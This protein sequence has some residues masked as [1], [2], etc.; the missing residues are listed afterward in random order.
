MRVTIV[1]CGSIGKRHSENILSLGHQV[2][3]IDL[4]DELTYD[5]D[6][7]F[8][9][10]P[11]QFHVQHAY[12]FLSRGIP[13]FIEKPLTHSLK[14][15]TELSKKLKGNDTI[16]MVGCNLRFHPA[17]RDAKDIAS[18]HRV[19]FARAEYGYYLPF[20]RKGDYRKSYSAGSDGGIIIDDI[21][22]IDYLYWLFGDIVD[23]KM[24]FGK[25]SDL[26]IQQED[27]SEVAIL[28]QNGVSA[29]VHQDYLCKNYHRT[30][31]L[32][33]GHETVR[34]DIQPTNLMYKKEIEYFLRCVEQKIMPMNNIAEATNVLT[35]I[36]ATKE[37]CGNN[38]NKADKHQ[39]TTQGLN[40]LVRKDS[41]GEGDRK[42]TRSTIRSKDCS[43]HT[44]SYPDLLS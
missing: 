8:V 44:T 16:S 34:F 7:A 40:G 4:G 15:L 36:L 43:S 38:T 3:P 27:I 13:T 19:I 42:A 11:T 37:N 21:H 35:R 20:W 2:I 31:E 1:G 10:S 26:E 24:V 33:L 32:H 22:E 6:C 18:K 5:V 29:S 9:C 12:E 28:F 23:L 41:F 39:T 17:V 14:D 30:L 25:V